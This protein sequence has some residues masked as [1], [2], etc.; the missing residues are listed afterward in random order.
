MRS[1]KMVHSPDMPSLSPV[2]RTFC[3]AVVMSGSASLSCGGDGD[4]DMSPGA[5]SPSDAG[6]GDSGL[7]DSGAGAGD[8]GGRAR[9]LVDR[10]DDSDEY[11]V[12]IIRT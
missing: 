3:L 5:N 8:A 6:P 4:S 10:P 1:C 7:V 2:R 11:Q 12:H 9:T